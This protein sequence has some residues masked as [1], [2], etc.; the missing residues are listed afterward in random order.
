MV[1]QTIEMRYVSKQKLNSLRQSLFPAESY[2]L[3]VGLRTIHSGAKNLVL[4]N[5]PL[6]EWD[7][8]TESTLTLYIPS[9]LIPVSL[10][11]SAAERWK[12]NL[13]LQDELD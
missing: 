3:E 4:T 12:L 5:T 9:K 13:N 1:A 7:K 10:V 2:E 11:R 6:Q 8:G